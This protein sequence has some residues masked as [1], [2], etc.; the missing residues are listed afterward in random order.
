MRKLS[1]AQSEVGLAMT[2]HCSAHTKNNPRSL[3]GKNSNRYWDGRRVIAE[4]RIVCRVVSTAA[5]YSP[6]KRIEDYCHNLL[7]RD[8]DLPDPVLR[9]GKSECTLAEQSYIHKRQT[10]IISR[11]EVG[12]CQHRTYVIIVGVTDPDM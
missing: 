12:T 2:P 4:Y 11:R 6:T 5:E 10:N 9:P 7:R 8:W 3:R 1:Q